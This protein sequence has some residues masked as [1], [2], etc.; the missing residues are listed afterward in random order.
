MNRSRYYF[1]LC[2]ILGWNLS[3]TQGNKQIIIKAVATDSGIYI[4]WFPSDA[5]EWKDGLSTG[6][7]ISRKLDNGDN[8]DF[9]ERLIIPKD[10]NWFK[11]NVKPEDGVLYPIGE[12]LYNPDF[13]LPATGNNDTWSLKY[14]YIV[15]EAT[16][17]QEVANIVGLGFYDQSS[18]KG[19]KYIYTI[20]HN[21]SGQTKDISISAESGSEKKEPKDFEHNFSFPDGNSLSYMY[22]LSK[23]FVLNAIIG[24][25]RPKL[26]SIVLR[27]GPTTPEIW[28]YAITD[29][30]D[31]YRTDTDNVSKK[32]ASVFPWNEARFRQIPSRDTLALLAASFVKDKGQPQ[33]MEKE[34]FF[35]KANMAS[36]YHGFALMMADRSALAADILGLRYVDRDVKPGEVYIYSIETKRLESNLP[37]IDIRVVN[38]YEPLLAPEGFSILKGEKQVTLKWLSNSNLTKYGSYV[39]ERASEKDS[40][41]QILTDPPLVFVKEP[42]ISQPYYTFMD[43]LSNNKIVYRYRVRGSNA[44]GEWSE[45]AY[46]IGY[47]IDKTPPDAVNIQSGNYEE[48]STRLRISWKLPT[49][50]SDIMYHQV[51]L[52]DNQEY[53]YSAISTELSPMDSVFYLNVNDMDTDRP[54]YFKVMTKDSSGNEAMSVVRY[55]SV[56]DLE[57]PE[58]PKNLKV[59]ID[60]LGMIFASW[61]PSTSQDVEGYY[62]YY[63]NDDGT[64]LTTHNDFLHKETTYSWSIPLNSLTKSIYIGVKAEDDNFNRSFISDIIKLRRP[65]TIAP[66]RPFLSQLLIEDEMVYLQWKRSSASDVEKYI[67]YRK[68]I[69]DSTQHWIVLD[70]VSNNNLEYYDGNFPDDTALEYAIKAMDDFNNESLISNAIPI[71]TPFPGSKYLINFQKVEANPNMLVEIVWNTLDVKGLNIQHPFKYQLFRSV[72]NEELKLYKEIDHNSSNYS[73]IVDMKNVL[74]NYAIRVKFDHDKVGNLSE[75]KSVL[76]K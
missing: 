13:S 75:V 64:D 3:F 8:T 54:F 61:S 48:D 56:P 34:N 28:R 5:N 60:S 37:S 66:P 50:L 36:N 32:I 31:I 4:H 20:K 38:E 2:C 29:G 62:I 26:D 51:F 58:A 63:S 59:T 12:I 23:P 41:F 67:I 17:N 73:E 44:F 74:Y 39:I 70:T 10:Q 11:A 25:A 14:N 53:N 43:S 15:Y 40:I 22:Q 19:A 1:V 30:Y 45:Y 47:G 76:I 6:Y 42:S 65:D 9:K 24:K 18:V 7:T 57:K 49:K 21:K 27:W 72:G 35:E 33:K 68:I 71:K 55:V 46:G 69:G 52:S 16:Q